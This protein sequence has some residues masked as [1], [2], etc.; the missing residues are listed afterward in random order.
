MS[1]LIITIF[2]QKMTIP[3]VGWSH[4]KQ[5]LPNLVLLLVCHHSQA[6]HVRG[7]VTPRMELLIL[8]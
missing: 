2:V 7:N 4:H 5:I 6:H 1:Q 3:H 8:H